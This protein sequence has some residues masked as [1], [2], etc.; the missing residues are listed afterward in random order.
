LV[1][2][3]IKNNGFFIFVWACVVTNFFIIRPTS[4]TDF[5][6]LL[7]AWNSICFGQCLCP[8]SGVHS[9]Y[10]QQWY[11][12]YR[13][14]ESLR[15]GPGWKCSSIMLLLEG[16]LQT[17]MK[18]T[19]VECTVNKSWWW[20]EAL[21]ETCQNKY[22][23]LVHLVGFYYKGICYDAR[24]REHKKIC[25]YRLQMFLYKG[26]NYYDCSRVRSMYLVFRLVSITQ[27]AYHFK[28][29]FEI[30]QSCG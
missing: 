2:I 5:E 1:N 20:A 6:N 17:C 3:R 30:L 27:T 13:F 9:L 14:V 19:I 29:S 4:C 18:Y 12:S 16:C 24:W 28:Q 21:S 22:G 11:M 23:K 25:K 8:S 26:K 15:A 10:T 7:L